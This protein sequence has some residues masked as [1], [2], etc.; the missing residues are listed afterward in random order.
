MGRAASHGRFTIGPI[1]SVVTDIFA[2]ISYSLYLS[3][4]IAFHL[5]EVN[6][7]DQLQGHRAA[8]F[9]SYALAVLLL[10]AVLHYT[11]E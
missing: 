2:G 7:G 3:H 5:V 6:P 1:G 11:I 4:K 8:T 10:G 9:A